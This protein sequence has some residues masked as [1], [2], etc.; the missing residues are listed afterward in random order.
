MSKTNL[1]YPKVTLALVG[2]LVLA[3]Q[4]LFAQIDE[5]SKQT[6]PSLSER[7]KNWPFEFT[8]FTDSR[9]SFRLQKDPYQ[10]NDLVLSET[11]V[12]LTLT[13]WHEWMELQLKSD[14]IYDTHQEEFFI[15]LREANIF[16]TPSHWFD[17]KIGRQ[18]L[19]WGKG[20]MLFVNDLFPKD[21]QSFFIGREI[22]YLKYVSDAAKFSFY[23][24]GFELNFIYVP[25][26]NPDLFPNTD[27]LSFYN[28]FQQSFIGNKSEFSTEYSRRFFDEQEFHWRLRKNVKGFDIATYG[29]YGFWKSPAGIKYEQWQSYIS[30]TQCPWLIHRRESFQRN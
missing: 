22:E 21:W 6:S 1:H 7:I 26:F 29:Y 12:Q 25:L 4:P 20:D 2:I 9:H 8:G 27:R 10:S 5:Q 16:L 19:T 28:P 18:I 17:V 14:F 3:I 24:K 30:R 15:G 11:K 23:A 13:Y